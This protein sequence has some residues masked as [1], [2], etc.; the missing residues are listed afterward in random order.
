MPYPTNTASPALA[1][2]P[3]RWAA[4][5]ALGGLVLALGLF[6]PARWLAALVL[7]ASG[8]HAVLSA[9]RGSFWQG[10]G[11]LVLSGGA[12]SLDAVAL[13]GQVSW[14]IRPAWTGMNLQLYADCCMQQAWRLQARPA[15]W[16]G[17][18]LALSDSQSQWPAALLT[19]LGTPWNTVQAQGRLAASTQGLNARWTQGR[20]AL[21][22]R[23]QID[24]L[25]I[26]SRL[27]TLRPMGSYRLTL[28][29]GSPPALAL[30]TLDGS[31]QLTGQGQ[32]VGQRLRF[33]GAA[34]ASPESVDALSNLLNIIGRRNGATAVITVG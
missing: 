22:G 2:A 19:G 17:L 5:G 13:P 10:S 21:A 34:S 32:W 9:P 11:Q 23:L 33:N 12:G 7:Q 4:A 31:L 18:Q 6:A 16:G 29:G 20:L 3:W 15:G 27:S 24:A 26:S 1:T 28:T 8:G 14:R 30:S 25:Q